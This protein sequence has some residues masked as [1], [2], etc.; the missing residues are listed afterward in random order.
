ML[1][2]ANSY[3]EEEL[4]L[5]CAQIIKYEINCENVCAFYSSAVKY[6]LDE[7]KECCFSFAVKN[8][9]L[10]KETDGYKQTEDVSL[11]KALVDSL[12]EKLNIN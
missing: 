1:D 7:L 11:L 4:K 5:K 3:F 12:D 6:D 10:I 9:H 8:I 2:L